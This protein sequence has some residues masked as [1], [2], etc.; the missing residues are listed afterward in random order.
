[1]FWDPNEEN[2]ILAAARFYYHIRK[3]SIIPIVGGDKIPRIRSWKK[4]QSEYLEPEQIEFWFSKSNVNIG[5][6]TGILSGVVVVDFD[7]KKNTGEFSDIAKQLMKEMPPTI[8]S[9]TG[10]G[11]LHYFFKYPSDKKLSNFV[12]KDIG[13]DFRGE[14]G[15]VVLPPSIHS[16]G[17]EYEFIC[18]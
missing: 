8:I 6:I 14:G 9:R 1:M 17:K 2:Q 18:N 4:Y 12:K 11:G 15:Y 16:N 10:S 7:I 5:L 3:W 13:V